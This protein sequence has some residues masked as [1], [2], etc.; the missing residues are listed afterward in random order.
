[1]SI[2]YVNNGRLLRFPNKLSWKVGKTALMV[3]PAGF[4]LESSRPGFATSATV[5][6]LIKPAGTEHGGVVI[7]V[8][9]PVLRHRTRSDSPITVLRMHTPLPLTYHTVTYAVDGIRTIG[10][11][12][13]IIGTTFSIRTERSRLNHIITMFCHNP[14]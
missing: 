12:R 6:I 8:V 2:V 9:Q 13:D 11:Y 4:H 10:C 3:T 5:S 1:M 7:D 14:N